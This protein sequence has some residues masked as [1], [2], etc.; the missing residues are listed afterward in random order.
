LALAT[1]SKELFFQE[2]K[3][4]YHA[5]FELSNAL[6]GKSGRLITVCGIFIPLLFGFSSSAIPRTPDNPNLETLFIG[7]LA[8]SITSAVASIFFSMFALRVKSYSHAFLHHDFYDDSGKLDKEKIKKYQNQD[9]ATF[10]DEMIG[11]YLESNKHNLEVNHN[12]AQKIKISQYLFLGSLAI[13]PVLVG[14][15]LLS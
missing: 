11:E 1:N 13:V 9:E 8:T 5:Q 14:L 6:E 7:L 15:N 4:E 10:Y 12:K 2:L 3:E